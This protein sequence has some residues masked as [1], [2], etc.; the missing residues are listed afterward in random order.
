[1]LRDDEDE[2][3]ATHPEFV[4]KLLAQHGPDAGVPVVRAQV[5]AFH[6][7]IADKWNT[8]RI[9]L[10]GDAAHLSPPFAGQGMNSGLRDAFNLGWKLAAVTKR[11]FGPELLTTYMKSANRMP[12]S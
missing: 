5:Y 1:M 11:Q 10:A 2:N 6:A 7:L 8:K 3:T 4:Q 12:E 9:F